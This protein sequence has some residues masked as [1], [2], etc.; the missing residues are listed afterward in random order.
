MSAQRKF[1][2]TENQVRLAES[3]ALAMAHEDLVRPIVEKYENDI[4]AKHQF[5]I[6]PRWVEKGCTDRLILNRKDAYLLPD[7]DAQV[8]YAECYAAR[9][10]AGLKVDH[11]EACPLLAAEYL[12]ITAEN[13]LLAEMGKIPGLESL[14]KAFMSL[15]LKARAVKLSLEL[16]APFCRNAD[17]ILGEIKNDTRAKV[18]P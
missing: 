15:E 17:D 14:G 6:A 10:A 16:L 11:P 12:R 4:L 18:K 3:L 9:D 5:R 8:F 13:E 7:D 2:P 1:T